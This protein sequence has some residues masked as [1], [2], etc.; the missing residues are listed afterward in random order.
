[1]TFDYAWVNASDMDGNSDLLILGH[2]FVRRLQEYVFRKDTSKVFG[3]DLGISVQ[4]SDVFYRGVAGLTLDRLIN[5]LP[6]VR[7]LSPKA[8]IIDIGTNDLSNVGV[9]PVMLAKR[10]IDFAKLVAAV[11]SVAEVLVCQVLPRVLVRPTGRTRFPTRVDFNDAR[12]MVNRTLAA[13]TADLP[14]IHYWRHRGMH[15]NWQQ[16]F[17]RFGV[18]LNDAGMRKYVRSIRGAAMFAADRF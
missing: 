4:F 18:H 3:A 2:S 1:M 14:H 8:E 5:E 9:D 16:Y 17:D 11:N 13:L 10:I 6:L 12:F 7:D 15:A